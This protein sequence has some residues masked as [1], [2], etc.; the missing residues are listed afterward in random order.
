[1]KIRE[2]G[3]WNRQKA[4]SEVHQKSQD[5]GETRHGSKAPGEN[6]THSTIKDKTRAQEE[7]RINSS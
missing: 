7:A 3:G 5:R 2:R 4:Y 1:M 6:I